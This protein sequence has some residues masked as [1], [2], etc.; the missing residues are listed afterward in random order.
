MEKYLIVITSNTVDSAM[1]LDETHWIP[2]QVSVDYVGCLLQILA[3]YANDL[4][5]HATGTVL[6]SLPIA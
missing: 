4:G 5:D 2:W 6:V 3:N 1:S